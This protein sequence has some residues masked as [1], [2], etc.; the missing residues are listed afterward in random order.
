MADLAAARAAAA[1]RRRGAGAQRRRCC[2]WSCSASRRR[3][4]RCTSGCPMTYSAAA[5]PVAA[6][7]AIMTK[8]GVYAIARMYTLV[9]GADGGRGRRRCARPG[10]RRWRWPR[11]RWR[12]RR[13]G[14]ASTARAD[15][16]PGDRPR[17][18]RC[19]WR[20]G[21][22]RTGTVAAGL[23]YLVNSTLVV[24]VLFLL[25]DR[26][27]PARRGGRRAGARGARPEAATLGT[28]FFSSRSP[29]PG[30]RRSPASSASRCCSRRRGNR[31][32]PLGLGRRAG[33]EPRDHRRA[34]ARGQRVFWRGGEASPV[35]DGGP[36]DDEIE[37]DDR[38]GDEGEERGTGTSASVRAA[39]AVASRPR[40]RQRRARRRATPGPHSRSA[41]SPRSRLR[42]RRADRRYT[43]ATAAQLFDRRPYIDAVLGRPVPPMPTCARCASIAGQGGRR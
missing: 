29:S 41:C 32:L 34:G 23:F 15:R 39:E 13:A 3:C 16:L 36:G 30:C 11:W 20:S 8:V 31:D 33:R 40:R 7:F 37:G 38:A 42:R 35:G 24:A 14:R 19:C 12:G 28:A 17:P 21:S 22:A 43:G 25:V 27:A 6:L 4:C 5:A 1:R 18:A 10:C 2:C 26:I 9:F